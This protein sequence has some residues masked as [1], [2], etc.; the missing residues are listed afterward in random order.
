[1]KNSL[2]HSVLF[3][4]V[5]AA[6]TFGQTP[7]TVRERYGP[8]DEKGRYKVR[9]GI[10]LQATFDANGRPSAMTIKPLD[11]ELVTKP[12]GK[13]VSK[14]SIMNRNTAMAILEELV[15]ANSRGKEIAS[16]NESRGCTSINHKE[17]PHVMISVSLTFLCRIRAQ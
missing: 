8:P 3:V 6:F 12:N 2:M 1:M 16:F 14:P 15:P 9:D 10:G 13:V 17:H 4:L 5:I 7:T 11:P